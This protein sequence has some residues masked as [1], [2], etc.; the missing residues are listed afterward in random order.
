MVQLDQNSLITKEVPMYQLIAIDLDGTLLNEKGVISEEN[1]KAIASAEAAGV[2]VVIVSGRSYASTKQFIKELSLP[3]L[4]VSLNGAYIHDPGDDSL[5]ESYPIQ[6][7][8][9]Q[10]LL[11]DLEP[12]QAHVNFYH[13]E[14]LLCQADSEL[15][16]H[17]AK[18]NRIDYELVDSLVEFNRTAK[19]GKL[20]LIDENDK[21]MEIKDLL[22]ERYGDRLHILFSQATYLEVFDKNT[23]KGVAILKVAERYGIRPEEIIALGDNE[24]D[25]SMIRCAGMGIAMGNALETVKQ[26][27]DFVTLTNEENGVAY[28]INKFLFSEK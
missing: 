18:V 26:Q 19:A 12:Y 5:V 24:N 6:E 11:L 13:G 17:Y 15:I 27:A 21:L 4:T 16:Q 2:K 23:S 7:E 28:A 10:A 22:T 9:S 20:L 1:K 14:R 25:I 8:L 3:N